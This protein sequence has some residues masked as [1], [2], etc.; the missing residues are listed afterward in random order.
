LWQALG[1]AAWVAT[2]ERPDL[3]NATGDELWQALA[4][5]EY[6]KPAP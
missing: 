2:H 6:V 3:E 5:D 4:A 1:E